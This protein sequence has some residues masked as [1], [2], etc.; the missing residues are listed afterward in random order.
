MSLPHAPR[1]PA[2]PAAASSAAPLRLAVVDM[3]GT[4]IV[5][6]GLQDTAFAR[7]LD[8]HGVPAGT[9]EHDDAARR[10]RALRPTSRTAVFPRVFADRAVAAAATRT[11][12]A[13]FDALLA[14]HGV[15][16]VP[17]A[18]EALVRLRALGLHVC[19]CTGYARH[20]QNMILESL[21]WMGLAD[22]SLSPD[23][24]GRGVPYPDMI[25]TALL[26]L[27]HDD[28]RSV[29][30]VGD[31]AE[32]MTAGRRAGA[33]LVVG[34]RTGRDADDVLLA[35]GADRVVPGLADVPDLVVRTR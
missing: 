1:T 10:F 32:D 11:F 19:L 29:L 20:T 25:L 13:T 12:E 33:G 28:V 21:G 3:S 17:G 35:A 15:Q 26:G 4:S 24:A 5:E 2:P 31:T 6:H 34:V 7:T 18:E 14:E 9:P 16:A 22:L 8:Q 30:V 23:D 27:D